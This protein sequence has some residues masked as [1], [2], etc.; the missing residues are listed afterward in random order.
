MMHEDGIEIDDSIL[1]SCCG[2]GA[3]AYGG[4]GVEVGR[5]GAECSHS[6]G[7]DLRSIW[8]GS[9][10]EPYVVEHVGEVDAAGRSG[11]IA[12]PLPSDD[13][14]SADE[15]GGHFACSVPKKKSLVLLAVAGALV[16]LAIGVG[17]GVGSQQRSTVTSAAVSLDYCMEQYPEWMA[18]EMEEEETFMKREVVTDEPTVV[19]TLE[20]TLMPT[21]DE[22]A[23]DLDDWFPITD[24]GEEVR[25]RELVEEE[26]VKPA[27][28]ELVR[29]ELRGGEAAAQGPKKAPRGLAHKRAAQRLGGEP[30]GGGRK[31][32]QYATCD[33]LLAHWWGSK[34]GKGTKGSKSSCV[35]STSGKSGKSGN[36]GGKSGKSWNSND[37]SP[38]G[39]PTEEAS[40]SYWGK[41]GKSGS[42]GGK[43]SKSSKS[44][45]C[46]TLSPT[47]TPTAGPSAGPTA[48]PT[49]RP[50][51]SPTESPTGKPTE[52]PTAN[53][54]E[55]PTMRP[56]GEPTDNPTQSPT[57]RPTEN[58]TANP[59]ESPSQ[60]PTESPTANPT[61]SPTKKPTESPTAN[62]TKSPTKK[63][64]ESPTA[65]PTKSPTK[66]P[67]ASPTAE[68][69]DNLIHLVI[70]A[71]F[72]I[73]MQF[74]H[75]T[76]VGNPMI[77]VSAAFN[78]ITAVVNSNAKTRM[79]MDGVILATQGLPQM[80]VV[81][82]MELVH[83]E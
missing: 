82:L 41:S 6:G 70:R 53:P 31:L 65:N 33:E 12:V 20:P 24:D 34:A 57:K 66:R 62:P 26:E 58:P 37:Y 45:G 27:R 50:T 56:T 43:S 25:A 7:W 18:D 48:S 64:T 60:K 32:E 28:R 75:S 8:R 5:D 59:T 81:R 80:N 9:P 67:T 36:G 55:S 79:A 76:I 30:E 15:A 61:E 14:M 29:R 63:P 49:K 44:D 52:N 4:E 74:L 47:G 54:T 2:A 46:E 69:T 17:A 23:V 51:D 39:S 68:P 72:S 35:T 38:T 10:P 83:A 13:E 42:K 11:P 73:W 16:V 71:S 40:M 21:T 78:P 1:R 22:P 77:G 19:P 3:G